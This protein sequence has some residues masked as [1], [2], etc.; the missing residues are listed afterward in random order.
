MTPEGYQIHAR[1]TINEKAKDQNY[2]ILNG[3][4]GLCGEAG[5]VADIVKKNIF[6][7]HPLDTEKIAYELG[8]VLW[9]ISLLC[10]GIGYPL[11]EVMEMNIDKLRK[12]YPAGFEETKS[13]HREE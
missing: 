13:I 11:E 4:L 8:D 2:A 7:G 10:D 5:E 9:Y 3:A 1:R 6:Q 12:R